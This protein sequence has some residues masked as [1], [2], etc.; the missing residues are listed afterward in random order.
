MG[1]L[2]ITV[3]SLS[4]ERVLDKLGREQIMIYSAN[5][6]GKNEITFEVLSKERKKV[7][8]ILQGSC[9]NVSKVR[10][11]G[12][13]LLYK[14]CL[15]GIGFLLG[16][17]LFC[18]IV[19]SAQSRILKIE[20]V[21]SGAY[22]EREVLSIL[23]QKGVMRFSSAPKDSALLSA[24]ILS[25]PL[26]SYCAMK[27]DGGILTV[28]VRVSS[29]ESLKRFE[30]LLTPVSG[31]VEELIV[32]R[33]TP[34]VKIGDLVE[35]GQTLVEPISFYGERQEKTIVIAMA[36]ISFPISEVFSGTEEEVRAAAILKYGQISEL[37]IEKTERGYLVS[38]TAYAD[39]AMNLE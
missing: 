31:K 39:A 12:L 4:A 21:G 17:V 25:L 33:G 1:K 32:V 16:A 30:P 20:V 8:A 38:G 36:T 22:Y 14:K 18:F 2:R 24:E 6:V 28:E 9:Y 19:L 34:Q 11:R 35:S 29:E 26:V 3:S 15:K 13:T 27:C 23:E 37:H 10:E 7:F 5:K